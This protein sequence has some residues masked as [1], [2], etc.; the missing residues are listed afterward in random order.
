MILFVYFLEINQEAAAF[1]QN[2]AEQG[3][4]L[5][6]CCGTGAQLRRLIF[7]PSFGNVF[8]KHQV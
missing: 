5:R 6:R 3:G 2:V 7:A 8:G 1:V 4:C